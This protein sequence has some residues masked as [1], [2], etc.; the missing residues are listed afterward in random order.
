[1]KAKIGYML[2][3][4]RGDLH[5]M[6]PACA[7]LSVFIEPSGFCNLQCCFCPNIKIDK[8]KKF[9]M[10]MEMFNKI[11]NQIGDFEQQIKVFKFCGI[12]ESLV[13]PNFAEMVR[14]V[15]DTGKVRTIALIS[16]CVLLNPAL[17]KKL[18][19]N[20]LNQLTVS[21]EALTDDGYL[22]IAGV[23]VDTKQYVENLRHLYDIKGD[24]LKIYI[25]INSAAIK[26]EADKQLF[27]ATY[28]DIC[29]EIMI[30]GL[31]HIFPN[32]GSEVEIMDRHRYSD[33]RVERRKICAIFFKTLAVAANGDIQQCSV[34]WEHKI[35]Y[36]NLN[37]KVTLKDA[38][39]GAKRFELLTCMLK[40]GI[41]TIPACDDCGNYYQSDPDNLDDYAGEI[42]ERL[43]LLEKKGR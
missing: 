4:D 10:P 42:L 3:P 11:V 35:V 28:G 7:P 15:R 38:W 18:V 33:A 1:M 5:K 6:V 41:D 29:D 26:N 43:Y 12:G 39:F 27:F 8:A 34:D 24:G 22:D 32:F 13:H 21:V 37:D 31:S 40:G 25:K 16:N 30:E 17:N 19:D 36:G 14:L 23:R 2:H 9:T 20:G